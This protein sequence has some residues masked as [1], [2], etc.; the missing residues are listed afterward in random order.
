MLS[1]RTFLARAV[2]TGLA[3]AGFSAALSPRPA[4]AAPLTAVAGS[5]FTTGTSNT[6]AYSVAFHPSGKM[7]ASANNA[8]GSAMSSVTVF[9]VQSSGALTPSTGGWTGKDT[10]SVAFSPDG[11]WLAASNYGDNSVSLFSV[12]PP[13]KAVTG[14][15]FA[16]GPGN[17]PYAVAFAPM[18][19]LQQPMFAT[20]DLITNSH[21]SV[22]AFK[23]GAWQPAVNYPNGANACGGAPAE[24]AFHPSGGWL[25][26]AN[27]IAGS[28]SVFSVGLG[29]VLTLLGSLVATGC[30]SPVNT[31]AFS[32][33]GPIPNLLATGSGFPASVEMFKFS[34]GVLTKVGS[35]PIGDKN[36]GVTNSVT[37]HPTLPLL[38]AADSS[39]VSLF[40]V[41][42]NGTL[43]L[44]AGSPF[45]VANNANPKSLAFSPD[46]KF[47]AVG[48]MSWGGLPRVW[49][50]QL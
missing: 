11:R 17:S 21:V 42:P 19:P 12:G 20:A 16:T 5:P 22:F 39:G 43:T 3:G 2:N 4:A 24:L 25:A 50:F 35:Q 48:T 8:G 37:F 30:N 33:N 26:C 18:G 46:G 38:A 45:A 6:I 47:L 13:F 7:L 9:T 27:G 14:S 34:M 41:M 36:T 15:P 49:M 40:E 31:L 10:T 28:V 32:P 1:R 44:M 23:A 29:G